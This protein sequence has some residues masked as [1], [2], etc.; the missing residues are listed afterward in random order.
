MSA[1]KDDLTYAQSR[2]RGFKKSHEWLLLLLPACCYLLLLLALLCLSV[3]FF[4]QRQR[5]SQAPIH[6][7]LDSTLSCSTCI[8][9]TDA[10]GRLFLFLLF[11]LEIFV[12][13]DFDLIFLV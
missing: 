8:F 12:S 7:S 4:A 3:C 2:R 9:P 10:L 5:Q 13:L 6:T 11:L 1:R